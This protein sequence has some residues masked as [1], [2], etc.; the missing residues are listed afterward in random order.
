MFEEIR[1]DFDLETQAPFNERLNENKY[2]DEINKIIRNRPSPVA[3]YI[4]SLPKKE[5]QDFIK[6]K[7]NSIQHFNFPDRK[8]K[9]FDELDTEFSNYTQSPDTRLEKLAQNKY[10]SFYNMYTFPYRTTR[11]Q[12]I[13][14]EMSEKQRGLFSYKYEKPKTPHNDIWVIDD[15]EERLKVGL[16]KRRDDIDLLKIDGALLNPNDRQLVFKNYV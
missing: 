1:Y 8:L 9:K 7:P 6:N 3:S 13:Q 2:F 12:N 11:E 16:T 14:D 5:V 15:K 4:P 10:R